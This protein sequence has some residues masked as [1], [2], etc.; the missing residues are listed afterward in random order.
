ML[1]LVKNVNTQLVYSIFK[2]LKLG[3]GV[4]RKAHCQ[5]LDVGCG[6]VM[7]PIVIPP[8]TK[9]VKR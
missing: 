9:A 5:L 4:K 2:A 1:L 7:A 6:E 3:K 8:K